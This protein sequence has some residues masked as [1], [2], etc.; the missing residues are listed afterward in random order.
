MFLNLLLKEFKSGAII[1][2][3]RKKNFLSAILN[4]VVSLAF[5]FL[6][7][8]I[9]KMLNTKL[10]KFPGAS[11]AFLS[12]FLFIISI[13]HSLYLTT[14]VRKT[15]YSKDDFDIL[16]SKPVTPLMNVMSKI[17][18][19]YL[20][21]VLMNYLI[22]FPVLVVYGYDNLVISRVMFLI[23]MYPFIISI[24]ETGLAYLLSIPYQKIFS[25]L[26]KHFVIQV[27][28]SIVIAIGLCFVYSYILNTFLTLVRDNNIY[29]IFSQDT[30]N[31]LDDIAKYLIPTCFFIQLINLDFNGLFFISFVSIAVFLLGTLLSS[32][33]YLSSIYNEKENKK[34][35]KENEPKLYSLNKA[36]IKKEL[37]LYFEDSNSIFSFSSLLIM[38]PFL[39]VLVIQAMNTIFK[40]G[41][42]SYVSSFFTYLLPFIQILFIA[43]FATFINTSASFVISRE[44]FQGVRICKTIP[45]SYKK[46]IFI[47]M[48][49]PFTLSMIS[50]LVTVLVL[51][52]TKQISV[53]YGLLALLFT[54]L[55]VAFLELLSISSDLKLPSKEGEESNKGSL[56]SLLSIL[57]PLAFVGGMFLLTYLNI[58]LIGSYFI[59]LGLLIIILG[60]Y[61][62]YFNKVMAKRFVALEMRN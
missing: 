28:T 33:L 41:I 47:K 26:K 24:F 12:L 45:V 59:M 37:A 39:T 35:N 52:I 5:V 17:V 38:E 57:I 7:I 48:V 49:V 60:G 31:R 56:I 43:L 34:N 58:P 50:L 19:V 25:F 15:L 13:A 4:I 32:K 14:T 6:E 40:T 11:Q 1:G 55:L 16:M 18:F 27:I 20:R 10:N 42:L 23:L 21:D 30:I 62:L 51:M 44:K 46:Q 54:I 8:Y 22:S 3:I 2:K 29:A 53:A 61:G 9:F 36:L